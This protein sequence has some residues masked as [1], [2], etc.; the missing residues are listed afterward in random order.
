MIP[1]L[2]RRS[3]L[4]HLRRRCAG[5]RALLSAVHEDPRRSAGRATISP[6]SALPRKLNLDAGRSRA[7][8]PDA[9]PPVPSR[10]L[11]QRL[12]GR[13]ARQPRAVLVPERRVPHAE[14]ADLRASSTCSSSKAC[15]TPSDHEAAAKQVPPALLEEVFALNEELDEVRELR[16]SGAPPE[17][18]WR[19][20]LERAAA[21]I[22]AKRGEHEAAAARAVGAMGRAGRRARRR[23]RTRSVLERAARA[24]ARAQLHQQPARDDRARGYRTG[25]RG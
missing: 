15:C 24:D 17:A 6:F 10:L 20:R 4:P 23:G 1:P 25:V 22:E 13:T 2:I 5:R 19:A 3:G 9:E 21:P 14:A 11:L 16:A 18:Q 7:A 8:V 12:A